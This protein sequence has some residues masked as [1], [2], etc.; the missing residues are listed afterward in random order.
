MNLSSVSGF[1]VTAGEE[2]FK[3]CLS[4]VYDVPARMCGP[5]A[6]QHHLSY[7]TD[8]A[9][10][11]QIIYPDMPGW[12]CIIASSLYQTM[13]AAV[14]FRIFLYAA[15]QRAMAWSLA[16]SSARH[17]EPPCQMSDAAEL[18]VRLRHAPSAVAPSQP[19]RWVSSYHCTPEAAPPGRGGMAPDRYARGADMWP[20]PPLSRTLDGA[21]RQTA[22]CD[23]GWPVWRPARARPA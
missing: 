6:A 9:S 3:I 22:V 18:L 2:V 17:W 5:R 12:R 4:Y 7:F 23:Q 11:L 16:E 15:H 20:A 19:A 21:A 13:Y 10:A 14:V 8:A 1:T